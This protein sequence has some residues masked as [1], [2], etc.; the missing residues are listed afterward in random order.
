MNHA[1]EDPCLR[2]VLVRMLR[3]GPLRRAQRP[4]G[5]FASIW[6]EC[7]GAAV[8]CSRIG[9]ARF[10]RGGAHPSTHREVGKMRRTVALLAVAALVL[11]ACGGDIEGGERAG[12]STPSRSTSA[13]GSASASPSPEIRPITTCPCTSNSC[14]CSTTKPQSH[15]VDS[16]ERERGATVY[17]VTHQSS[18]PS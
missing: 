1:E 3:A 5:P 8:E 18:G 12:L 14:N 13:T 10:P 4:K 7:A 16:R 15:E 2:A 17:E 6:A 11:S 9:G